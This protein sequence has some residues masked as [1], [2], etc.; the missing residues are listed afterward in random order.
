MARSLDLLV[1]CQPFCFFL[2]ISG[3]QGTGQG[4]VLVCVLAGPS[5]D[6]TLISNTVQKMADQSG[7]SVKMNAAV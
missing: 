1:H 3:M 4:S 2:Q 7:V 5:K 6:L